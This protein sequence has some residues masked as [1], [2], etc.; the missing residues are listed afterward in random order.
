MP[1]APTQDDLAGSPTPRNIYGEPMPT[2]P[3]PRGY[4]TYRQGTY[5]MSSG[6]VE[7]IAG[8]E[9]AAEIAEEKRR[10]Q[11]AAQ[12]AAA[13]Q[14]QEAAARLPSGEAETSKM[15]VESSKMGVY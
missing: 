2:A 10:R 15:E 5:S 12:E 13:K 3:A 6:E 7:A 14:A 11:A 9:K 8:P 4:P 1:T